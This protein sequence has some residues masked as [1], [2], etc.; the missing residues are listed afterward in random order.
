MVRKRKKLNRE[1]ILSNLKEAVEELQSIIE[2]LETDTSYAPIEFRVGMEHAY[3]HINTAWNARYCSFS[4]Y[5]EKSTEEDFFR[6]REFPKNI[7][8]G[9][10]NTNPHYEDVD[11]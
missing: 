5:Y 6:W 1:V 9:E 2:D 4:E 7:H 3:H 10:P 8:M 11:E